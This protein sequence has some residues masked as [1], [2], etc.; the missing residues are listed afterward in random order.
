M[1]PKQITLASIAWSNAKEHLKLLDPNL[2][3]EDLEHERQELLKLAG[4]KPDETGRRSVKT[5]TNSGLSTFLDLLETTI[6]G[7]P[8]QK[9]RSKA[10]TWAV[11]KLDMPGIEHRDAYL[12]AIARD[13]FQAE[14][15]RDLT[16][17]NLKFL[18][19]TTKARLRARRQK[20]A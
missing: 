2:D 5:L 19:W 16:A 14:N 3:K 1:T 15:W 13:K 18:L 7:K 20:T 9:R 8:N 4:A 6:S 10:L 11:E 17:Q 12:N